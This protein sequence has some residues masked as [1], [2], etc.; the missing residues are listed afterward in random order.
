MNTKTYDCGLRLVH[1]K[2][3]AISAAVVKIYCLV[4]GRDEDDT[5]RG[6]AHLLE[7][8]FFK[9][10]EKR[11]ARQINQTFDELG[12]VINAFTDYDRTC[13][14][15]QGLTEYLDTIFDVMSDCLYCSTFDAAE[16]AKEKTVVCSELEMYENDF[17]S[18]AQT[19]SVIIGLQG[20]GYDYILGGTVDSVLRLKTEDLIRFRDRWYTPDRIVVSVCGDVDFE[21]VDQLV[22]KYLLRAEFG[23]KEPVSFCRPC[24]A[25]KKEQRQIFESKNTDQVYGVLCFRELNKSSQDRQAFNL[26]RLALGSTSTSRLFVKLREEHGLVY[27]VGASP[28]LFG[29]CGVNA[30]HFIASEQNAPKVVE[31]IK[32]TMD[33]IKRDGFT[34]KELDT[35][36]NLS[37]TSLVL[38]L[39]TI[40]ARASRN[41]ENYIY[42]DRDFVLKDELAQIDAVTLEQMNA[43]F[44]KYYDYQHLTSSIVSQEDKVDVTKIF[45][46]K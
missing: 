25:V 14:H 44:K 34:Q 1:E 41:G 42:T 16:L 40:T 21:V 29:D 11:T 33:E 24:L 9:G 13:Y 22:Q 3:E 23:A 12:I 37:K 5:N 2:N 27:V 10:T 15:A 8:M 17:E 7:H 18:V 19:N 38:S 36:K 45:G 30:V 32:E 6:I 28:T 26:A 4:G 35:F 20:T 43:A 31:L 46:L 39:Q